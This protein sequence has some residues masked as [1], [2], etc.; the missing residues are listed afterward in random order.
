[1]KSL[2]VRV[3]IIAAIAIAY[4]VARPFISESAGSLKLG[5]CFDPPT[6]EVETVNDVQHHPCADPHGGEVIFVGKLVDAQSA[7]TSS[8]IEAWVSDNCF[9][10]YATYTGAEMG[11]DMDMGYFSPTSDGWS[12]GDRTMICYA[13]KHDYS[14][15]T[16]SL[17]KG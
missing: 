4:F 5:D 6:A 12:K 3:G 14:N 17:K 13:A 8:E 10:A 16:G 2:A 7:P 1:M 11:D 9:P 15:L